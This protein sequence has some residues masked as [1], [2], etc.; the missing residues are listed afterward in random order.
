MGLV[1]CEPNLTQFLDPLQYD[2]HSDVD[3]LSTIRIGT[4]DYRQR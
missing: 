1:V 3:L 4:T 2:A